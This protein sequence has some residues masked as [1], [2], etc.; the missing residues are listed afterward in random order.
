MP[1]RTLRSVV[2]ALSVGAICTVLRIDSAPTPR[3][4]VLVGYGSSVQAAPGA[5]NAPG[6]ASPPTT[7]T[8]SIAGKVPACSQERRSLSCSRLPTPEQAGDHG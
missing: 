2:I 8:F 7:P 6:A 3:S 4:A 5:T 1:R